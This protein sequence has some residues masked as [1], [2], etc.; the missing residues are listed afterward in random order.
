M[1]L[2]ELAEQRA[3]SGELGGYLVQAVVDRGEPAQHIVISTAHRFA[4]GIRA[5]GVFI[6]CTARVGPGWVAVAREVD[7]D[8]PGRLR[9]G[10]GHCRDVASRRGVRPV[11]IMLTRQQQFRPSR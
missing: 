7:R 1:D 3:E 9:L 2:L 6:R 4:E 11:L 5:H 10:L 8:E